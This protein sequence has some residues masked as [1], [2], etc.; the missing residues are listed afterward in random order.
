MFTN[1]NVFSRRK[2]PATNGVYS[3]F[4]DADACRKERGAGGGKTP[5]KVGKRVYR[6]GGEGGNGSVSSGRGGSELDQ[7]WSGID[8][9]PRFPKRGGKNRVT[10]E[11]VI[12][13]DSSG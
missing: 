3:Y 6:K 7:A 4:T 13:R 10:E 1:P 12:V 9:R 5:S 2:T 8:G 11:R